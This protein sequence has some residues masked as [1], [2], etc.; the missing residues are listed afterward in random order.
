M[1]VDGPYQ[2]GLAETLGVG[3]LGGDSGNQA[4]QRIRQVVR[5][6]PAVENHRFLHRPELVVGTQG[7][8]LGD[9]VVPGIAAEGF[10]IVPEQGHEE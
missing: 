4:G 5:T 3:F 1:D 7:G 6:E 8:E 2:V 9:P 10:K